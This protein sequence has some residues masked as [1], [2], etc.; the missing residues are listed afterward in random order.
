MATLFVDKIDPQSGTSL[1][2]GSSGDTLDLSNPSTVTLNS[3]MK[4]TPAFRAYISTAPTFSVNTATKVVCDTEDFDTDNNFASGTFTPTVAGKYFVYGQ[5][6][7]SNNLSA[8]AMKYGVAIIKKNTSEL[9]RNN[10]D[11]NAGANANQAYCFL[12][13]VVTMNGSSDYLELFVQSDAAS[14][15]PQVG[16][17]SNQTWFGAYK[18]IE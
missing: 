12:G 3:V 9:I 11:P 16:D 15:T 7:I 17:N 5:V 8:D 6:S 2:I 13:T 1:E 14:G 18:I 4:N 10:V